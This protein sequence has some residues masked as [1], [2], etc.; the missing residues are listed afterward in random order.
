MCIVLR[1]VH[2]S[3]MRSDGRNLRLRVTRREE[4]DLGKLIE[5]VTGIAEARHRACLKG[6]PD[7]YGFPPP[8]DLASARRWALGSVR[9][10]REDRYQKYPGKEAHDE[11]R[12]TRHHHDIRAGR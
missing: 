4:P 6:E 12:D 9:G 7:P 3:G 2:L 1:R 10:A 11:H 5:W 8:E